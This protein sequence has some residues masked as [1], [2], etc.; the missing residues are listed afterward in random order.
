MK[1]HAAEFDEGPAAF[2]R[3][4]KAMKTIVSVP[5]SA[6]ARDIG[7]KRSSRKK[8]AKRVVG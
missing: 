2:E 4:R 3:F 1:H 5:K 8:R 7:K 6:I